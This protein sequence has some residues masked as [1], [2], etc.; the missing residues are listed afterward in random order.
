VLAPLLQERLVRLALQ[1]AD[2]SSSDKIEDW[3]LDHGIVIGI[4]AL[5]VIVASILLNIIVPRL[6][7]ATAERR[8][9]DKPDEEIQQRIDTLSHF[10]TRSGGSLFILLGFFMMLPELGVNIAPLLAGAG[11]AGIAVGFGAQSLVK[12]FFSGIFILIDNQYGKGDVVEIAGISGVVQDVGLRRTV[13]RDINGGV[14]F[15]PNGEIVVASNFTEDFSRVNLNV[16]VSYSEDLEHVMDVIDRVG[17]ELAADVDWAEQIISPPKALRVDN[18]G[19]SSID[20]KIL[21]DTR[22][23]QQWAV[24]GELRLRLKKA[25][26]AEGIEIPY[27][28]TQLVSKGGK[29]WDFPRDPDKSVPTPEERPRRTRSSRVSDADEDGGD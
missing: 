9:A 26:D 3:L 12:D 28:H 5:V 14:H 27:P 22:V 18:F 19:D 15:V 6:V 4:I 25:F 11:I 13:V 29:A 23:S 2:E 10:F 20:I 8:L 7:R 1:V 21:G 24:M 17:E 16:G